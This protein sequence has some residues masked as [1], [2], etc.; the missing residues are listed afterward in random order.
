M[1][2]YKLLYNFL[3]LSLFTMGLLA[4]TSKDSKTAE[5][6]QPLPSQNE[7]PTFKLKFSVEEA[8]RAIP[9]RQT[10]FDFYAANLDNSSLSYLK[11]V[12]SLIDQA[13]VVRVSGV[14]DF[15][16]GLIKNNGTILQYE[17]LSEFLEKIK[18]PKIL[19]IYHKNI[20]DALSDQRNVFKEWKNTTSSYTNRRSFS[21]GKNQKVKSASHNLRSAYNQLMKIFPNESSRNKQAF[22]DYHCALDFI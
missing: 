22:F 8:Y 18:P 7:I 6:L 13:I 11:V 3:C 20:M 12:F 10:A 19:D 14:D 2:T 1:N 17:N 21:V 15:H 5:P 4:C 16:K 9:H